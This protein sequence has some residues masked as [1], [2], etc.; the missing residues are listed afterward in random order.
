MTDVYDVV[1]V[2]ENAAFDLGTNGNDTAMLKFSRPAPYTPL[3]VVGV[4]DGPRWAAGTSA[5]IVGWGTT[6]S[7][8]PTSDD[9]LK[10]DVPVVADAGARP[11]TAPGST[12]ARW[13]APATASTTPARATAAG[14]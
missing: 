5:R 6:S 13:C 1:S 3:R 9:L 2:D 10:A 8:G 7:G 11:P 12:R 14:R 4:G